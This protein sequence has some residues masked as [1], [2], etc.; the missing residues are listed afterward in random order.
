MWWVS[1]SYRIKYVPYA[2]IVEYLAN[3]KKKKKKKTD[4]GYIS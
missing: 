3:K 4:T 2:G 1:V